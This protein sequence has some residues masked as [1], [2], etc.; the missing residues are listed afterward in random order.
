MKSGGADQFAEA[1]SIVGPAPP[2]RVV[3]QFDAVAA[4]PQGG[5]PDGGVKPPLHQIDTLP[6]KVGS[7]EGRNSPRGVVR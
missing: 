1:L 7:L 3:G 6:K 5:S 4:V 2:S